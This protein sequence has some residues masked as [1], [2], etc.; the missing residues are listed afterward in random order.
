VIEP[1]SGSLDPVPFSIT[2]SVPLP[3]VSVTVWSGPALAIG[4]SLTGLTVMVAV[5]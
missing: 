5:A 3:S 2:D 1:P 4:G